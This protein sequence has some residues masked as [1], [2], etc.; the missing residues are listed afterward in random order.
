MTR[1]VHTL[2]VPSS[3]HQLE[4]VRRFVEVHA[5][6]AHLPA[7][8]VEDVRIAVDEACSNIIKHAYGETG[9]QP[10]D[11][12]VIVAPNRFTVRI[13]DR[14]RPFDPTRYE[15][16]DVVKLARRRRGG[17]LG[18]YLMRQLMDQVEYR[19]RGNT[20]EVRLTKYRNGQE[21]G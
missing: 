4:K 21:N 6:Q 8:A 13:R 18:V 20:N 16:P 14:G 1:T 15:E 10:I 3:T 7:G 5:Q 9:E 11:I 2:T 12:A 19:T 17:G